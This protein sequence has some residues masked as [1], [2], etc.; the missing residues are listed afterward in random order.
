MAQDRSRILLPVCIGPCQVPPFLNALFWV[1]AQAMPFDQAIDAIA[2]ALTTQS[3]PSAQPPIVAPLRD[4]LPPF[5]RVTVPVNITQDS[6]IPDI[7]LPADSGRARRMAVM[8]LVLVAIIL[9]VACII[10]LFIA[11]AFR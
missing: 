6:S 11:G 2:A 3:V 8:I 4:T 1:D 5:G 7:P 10:I 9:G